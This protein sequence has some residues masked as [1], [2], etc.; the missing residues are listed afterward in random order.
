MKAI[1]LLLSILIIT[2]KIQAQ[3][4]V[5]KIY[6]DYNTFWE[7]QVTPGIP[8]NSHHLLAF[9]I[10]STVF[11]TGVNDALLQS[12]GVVFTAGNYRALPVSTI[13]NA[14]PS[15]Y[16][17]VGRMY[18]GGID[19]VTP[20][21]VSQP[22]AQY[23]ADGTNGLDLGTAIFNFPSSGEIVYEIAGINPNSIGDGIPD[24]IITQMG[25]ITP[26]ANDR[27][28]FRNSSGEI[29]GTQYTATLSGVTSIGNFNWK[30][31]NANANPPTYN[32]QIASGAR[33]TRL[34]TLDWADLGI[35]IDNVGEVTR[36]VQVFSGESDTSFTAY[37]QDSFTLR[38]PVS[39]F[40]FNDSN[41]GVPDG[42]PYQ[43]AIVSL[44]NS[45]GTI[46]ATTATNS[47]GYYLFSNILSGN[48]T[49]EL[50]VPTNYQVV[51][52]SEGTTSNTMAIT[53]SNV[54]VE[55]MNFGIYRLPCVKAGAT[56]TPSSLSKVGI[57][58]KVN[59]SI[60]NWPENVPNG[61]LVMD[62]STKG[63]VVTHMTDAQ[64]DL[65]SPVEGMLIYNTDQQCVQIYRG[66]SP[67]TDARRTGW[68]CIVRTC[69][70]E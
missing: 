43:N 40:V 31:Y 20:V 68:N 28:Y 21:P 49:I 10:G 57:H 37:N 59:Q 36:F 13:A 15:T 44:R 30:F 17:G 8:D 6:T 70:E 60:A 54:P 14:A 39:G 9:R 5:N 38:M 52:N 22:Y 53:I 3:A 65:L 48:Y 64:R 32:T 46:I 34:L 24:L 7:S 11:S 55:G 42:L 25:T 1:L 35:N 2:S 4:P 29:V 51:G 16:I 67:G 61:Y 63:F 58:T 62:A 12:R 45:S 50:T 18:G 69:N 33:A 66:N 26:N 19:N 23:L 56:G 47:S 27:F 41:A